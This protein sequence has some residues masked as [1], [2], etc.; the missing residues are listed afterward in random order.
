MISPE[1]F[2]VHVA[3]YLNPQEGQSLDLHV[4]GILWECPQELHL[5][6]RYPLW[7]FLQAIKLEIDFLMNEIWELEKYAL[8][9]RRSMLCIILLLKIYFSLFCIVILLV[10]KQLY[11]KSAGFTIRL[12]LYIYFFILFVNF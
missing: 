5:R 12:F 9:K 3:E 4:R 11:K 6:R 8:L 2:S 7:R 10:I 1:I